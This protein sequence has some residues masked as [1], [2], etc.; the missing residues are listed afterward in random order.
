LTARDAIW[1]GDLAMAIRWITALLLAVALVAPAS[2]AKWAGGCPKVAQKLNRIGHNIAVSNGG[3]T[4]Y[5]IS[6]L[7]EHVG[8]ELTIHLKATDVAEPGSGFSTEPG[9]NTLEV[10]FTPYLGTPIQLPPV[11]VTASS[12]STLTFVVPDT[13]PIIGR[14][15]V[16]PAKFIVRRGTQP[17]FE[18]DRLLIL[19]P[20]NDIGALTADGY[21][22]EAFG[23]LDKSGKLWVPLSFRSFG[24]DP[25]GG[26]AA[27]PTELTPV[28]AFALGLELKKG[29]DQALPYVSVGS[30]KSNK[31]FLGDYL[32]AN[33]RTGVLENMYGNKLHTKLAV[34]PKAVHGV[35]LCSLNDALELILL[36]G[37]RNPAL[38]KK[39]ELLELVRNGSPIRIKVHNISADLEPYI[40]GTEVDSVSQ[41]CYPV[42]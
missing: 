42:P 24:T 11:Q 5:A 13:R 28:T 6:K 29:E 17:L 4:P 9:G 31:L 34:V 23:T 27:C 37:L 8:H 40:E 12:T 32:L 38:G 35:V 33:P 1:E 3:A 7:F 26:L 36:V 15:L 39:S 25:D 41:P 2:A 14:L 21:E 30:L 10:T 22:V 19:P 16:G 18:V 20:M